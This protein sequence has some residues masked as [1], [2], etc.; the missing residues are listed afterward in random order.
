MH[1][2]QSL[3]IPGK[4]NICLALVLATDLTGT[5]WCPGSN[6]EAVWAQRNNSSVLQFFL[7]RN[8][9]SSDPDP[10]EGC[11]L[12]QKCCAGVQPAPQTLLLKGIVTRLLKQHDTLTSY[13]TPLKTSPLAH[14]SRLK[15]LS[16][17]PQLPGRNNSC[18]TA[19]LEHQDARFSGELPQNFHLTGKAAAGK[20]QGQKPPIKHR[21]GSMCI[22]WLVSRKAGRWE[23]L[24]RVTGSVFKEA[25]IRAELAVFNATPKGAGLPVLGHGQEQG[26]ER[27]TDSLGFANLWY[28]L[29]IPAGPIPISWL[30]P[31]LPWHCT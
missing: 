10:Q 4:G 15:P 16:P 27:A 23:R 12:A 13:W 9:H 11:L 20:Q 24:A 6:R 25:L 30:P 3:H 28:H 5:D 8:C 17:K 21:N 2:L 29:L 18:R 7:S 26:K 22:T 1:I 14:F 31:L 19:C